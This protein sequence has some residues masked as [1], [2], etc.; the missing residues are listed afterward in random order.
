[1][2]TLT[3]P[4]RRSL[5]HNEAIIAHGQQT[6][7][8]VGNALAAI[9]DGKLYRANFKTFDAYCRERW[10]FKRNYANKLIA[11]AAVVPDLGT[12]VPLPSSEAVAREVARVPSDKRAEVWQEAVERSGG[13][14]TAAE[15]KAVVAEEQNNEPR[16]FCSDL[17]ELIDMHRE[18][19]D[20]SWAVI[21]SVLEHKIDWIV[22]Q[23]SPQ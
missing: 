1:M 22:E 12:N 7:V 20:T 15:V 21:R 5:A 11:S 8:A 10:N 2:T 9:R 19:Y 3:V 14:P 18:D 4:E 16:S 23:E 13:K 6:F 17:D